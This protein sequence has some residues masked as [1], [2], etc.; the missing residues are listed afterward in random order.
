M[1]QVTPSNGVALSFFCTK[2]YYFQFD[3]AAVTNEDSWGK[4]LNSLMQYWE[5]WAMKWTNYDKKLQRIFIN[6]HDML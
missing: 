6:A 1:R 5:R 3:T 4:T 2:R